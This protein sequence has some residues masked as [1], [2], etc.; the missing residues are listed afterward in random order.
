VGALLTGVFAS[1][2][3]NGTADGLLYGNPAQLGIQ[4]LAVLAA[5]A[6]SGVVTF[7]LLKGLALVASLKVARREEGLGLDVSQHG[8]EAYADHE[9]AILV[10]QR[11]ETERLA[12]APALAASAAEG[13]RS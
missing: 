3:W 8:E 12:P 5:L 1:R 7:L 4:A 2:A 9:G 13:G 6:Y 10:L 11:P